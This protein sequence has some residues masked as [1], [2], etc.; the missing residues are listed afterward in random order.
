MKSSHLSIGL[1]VFMV[2]GLLLFV[3][4][5]TGYMQDNAITG[6][7]SEAVSG[8]GYPIV[9]DPSDSSLTP[10]T[11]LYSNGTNWGFGLAL[12]QTFCDS[13]EAADF[14]PFWELEAQFG[15]VTLSTEQSHDGTQSVKFSSI[16]GGNRSLSLTHGLGQIVKGTVSVWFY[17][18]APGQ[19][20]LYSHLDLW[21]STIPYGEPGFLFSVGVEDWIPDVYSRIGPD[22]I[23]DQVRSN[24]P[25]TLGWHHFEIRIG[26]TEGTIYID[27]NEVL[28][29]TG[30]YGFDKI[31]LVT[32]GPSWRPNATYYFDELCFVP[33]TENNVIPVSP[34]ITSLS[35]TWFSVH[36]PF[37][38][39]ANGNSYTHYAYSTSPDGPWTEACVKDIPGELAWR[40]C[41]LFRD[42]TPDTD[43]YAQITFYDDDGVTALNPLVLG[44]I[45][46][47]ATV[48]DA[49]TVYSATATVQD[50]HILVEVPISDD[51]N[52]NSQLA[53]V[54]IA[55]NENGP[56]TQ[57]CGPYATVSPK[58]C[59][60][61]S[62]TPGVDYW[63]RVTTSDPD[64]VNGPNPQLLGPITYT[65]LEN[66]ALEKPIG[67]NPGWGC[68]SDP[69]EL[70][71]GIIQ[72]QDWDYGFAWCG[73][74][75]YYGGCGPGWKQA[76]IDLGSLK[77][78]A[79]LDWWTHN[80]GNV[81]LEWKVEVSRDGVEWVEVFAG[82]EPLCRTTAEELAVE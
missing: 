65:G 57:K 79:R 26:E 43:Y 71:N 76:T 4:L 59:R 52:T 80:S 18:T 49:T 3:G 46:T 29:F 27:G 55:T 19:Q 35:S 75:D 77:T 14:D 37:G 25:R 63:I 6:I 56:W 62:L 39:D 48:V 81:P 42:L 41:Y 67:A 45:H 16:S 12:P 33:A 9:I 2:L 15:S 21:N 58:L 1:L 54:E 32:F 7:E 11:S 64:G 40:H 78:V 8:V 73:G 10:A 23:G 36:A 20:T 24:I 13:F 47:A 38:G 72:D 66:L 51:A 5:P 60:L 30:D 69:T 28:A 68:C 82:N 22:A 74:T 31:D 61:H 34:Q 50:T 44:P 70:V 17:D 53:S